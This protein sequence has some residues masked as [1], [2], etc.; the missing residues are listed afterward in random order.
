M[1][2]DV[3]RIV[4]VLEELPGLYRSLSTDPK[5]EKRVRGLVARLMAESRKAGYTVILVAQRPEAGIVGSADRA[6]C[7]TRISFSADNAEAVRLLFNITTEA[8]QMHANAIT[9]VAL[10]SVPGISLARVRSPYVPYRD[11]AA[12]VIAA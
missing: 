6:Q 9:G 1:S 10:I 5:A 2:P 11:Y 8:A 7:D 4:V 12:A 3:P